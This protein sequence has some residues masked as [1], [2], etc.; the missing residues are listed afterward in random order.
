MY[1]CEEALQLSPVVISRYVFERTCVVTGKN[2]KNKKQ[3]HSFNIMKETKLRIFN[4]E[5]F[6]SC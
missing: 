4:S 2:E 1:I 3:E 6:I 5:H